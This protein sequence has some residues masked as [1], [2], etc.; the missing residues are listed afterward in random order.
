MKS[1]HNLCPYCGNDTKDEDLHY[2]DR[3]GV[4]ACPECSSGIG[5]MHFDCE[6]EEDED[7]NEEEN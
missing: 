6:D 4:E 5:T 7:E 3:C 1:K 2:C